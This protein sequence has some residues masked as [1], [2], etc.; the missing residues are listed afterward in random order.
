MPKRCAEQFRSEP[1]S[2]DDMKQALRLVGS[3]NAFEGDKVA[4]ALDRVQGEVS[5][6]EFGREGSPV[7]YVHL[8]VWTNQQEKNC[9][10]KR[11]DTSRSGPRE[12]ARRLEDDERELL[13][14]KLRAVFSSVGASEIETVESNVLRVWW[15]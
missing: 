9:P 10:D 12:T 5:W 1:L 13:V 11:C 3:Y 2:S 6:Y 8:P 4:S 14:A 7:I 15:D